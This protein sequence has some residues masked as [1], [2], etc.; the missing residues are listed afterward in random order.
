MSLKR[1]RV[2]A[3]SSTQADGLLSPLARINRAAYLLLDQLVSGVKTL[4]TG[5]WSQ[6]VIEDLRR[7][8]MKYMPFQ[9]EGGF[10]RAFHQAGV[11][12]PFSLVSCPS[13]SRIDVGFG[14]G[15]GGL[16]FE[17]QILYLDD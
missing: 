3:R 4:P 7:M 9:T 12:L 10:C 1:L 13:I 2:A 8:L 5:V 15:G 11:N 16:M 14:W 17:Y 6:N